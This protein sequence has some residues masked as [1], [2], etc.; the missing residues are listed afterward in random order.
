MSG[1]LGLIHVKFQKD[2][3][4]NEKRDTFLCWWTIL[5]YLHIW[6][7]FNDLHE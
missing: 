7:G 2:V 1:I 4:G 6:E 5:L 3:A